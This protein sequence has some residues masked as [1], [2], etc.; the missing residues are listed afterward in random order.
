MNEKLSI[1]AIRGWLRRKLAERNLSPEARRELKQIRKM[2]RRDLTAEEKI[3]LTVIQDVCGKTYNVVERAFFDTRNDAILFVKTDGGIMPIMVNLSVYA[4]K[5]AEGSTADEIK[6][7]IFKPFLDVSG[8]VRSLVSMGS[9]LWIK[10]RRYSEFLKHIFAK[11]NQ[12]VEIEIDGRVYADKDI[13]YLLKEW[14]TNHIIR[15]TIDFTLKKDGVI[16][17][18]WHDTPDDFGV[19][20]SE[21]P[22]VEQLAAEKIVRYKVIF[23]DDASQIDGTKKKH[24]YISY[25]FFVIVFILLIAIV[26]FLSR[27]VF[28]VR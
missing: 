8:Q 14:C 24:N 7:E 10:T 23:E 16:L 27:I 22:F 25:I 4:R 9:V 12:N 28:P 17:F 18:G 6:K 26:S 20:M 19:A 5:I 2:P 21:R 3:V 15:R 13:P 1:S 11:Y